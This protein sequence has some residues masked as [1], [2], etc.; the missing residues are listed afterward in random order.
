MNRLNKEHHNQLEDSETC[1]PSSTMQTEI[2][3]T[4]SS[5]TPLHLAFSTMTMLS[6]QSPLSTIDYPQHVEDF[7]CSN[8]SRIEPIPGARKRRCHS[9]NTTSILFLLMTLFC[10]YPTAS[11]L[12]LPL[13]EAKIKLLPRKTPNQKTQSSFR[14]KV[15]AVVS[16]HEK[17]QHRPLRPKGK[18]KKKHKKK[19]LLQPRPPTKLANED[20]DNATGMKQEEMS[21]SLKATI[22]KNEHGEHVLLLSPDSTTKVQNAM[23]QQQ[24]LQEEEEKLQQEQEEQKSQEE[25]KEEVT[26]LFYDPEDLRPTKPGDEPSPPSRIYDEDGNEVELDGEDAILI[27]PP[28]PPKNVKVKSDDGKVK[29]PPPPPPVEPTGED[30]DNE[31][32][33]SSEESSTESDTNDSTSSGK[34]SKKSTDSSSGSSSSK[35]EKINFI[36]TPQQAHDQ[37][38]IISTVA[39]MALL[40]GA[41]TAR[42][43]RSRQFL[44]F[45]IENESLEDD[46]AYD[47]AYT[48]QSTVGSSLYGGGGYDTFGTGASGVDR[49]TGDLRWRGDLEKFDV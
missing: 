41:V 23:E 49:Y 44:N 24:K 13:V 22:G 8:S 31:A 25:E 38:I 46:L 5:R 15:E 40:V 9:Y 33:E 43:L 7:S 4:T 45:C 48:T 6:P 39:T 29:P 36:D 30:D 19:F 37:M 12:R 3:P 26:I 21:L 47:A 20:G 10:I 27:P 16:S 1:A 34:S 17:K 11:F 2:I 18:D 32:S 28:Q 14:R 42:R 35:S